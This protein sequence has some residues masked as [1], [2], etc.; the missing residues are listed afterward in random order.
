MTIYTSILVYPEGDT[1]EA[2]I[3]LQIDQ[4]VDLNGYPHVVPL[5]S[6]KM[7]AYRVSKVIKK[8]NKG[9]TITYYYLELLR[10]DELTE[11]LS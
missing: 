5:K 3:S 9:E 2:P 6:P 4:V 1:Q 8:E 10:R 11:Y 7:I